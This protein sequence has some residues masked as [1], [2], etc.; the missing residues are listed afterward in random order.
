MGNYKISSV[1]KIIESILETNFNLYISIF[2]EFFNSFNLDDATGCQLDIIGSWFGYP[3]PYVIDVNTPVFTYDNNT[4][5]PVAL[6]GGWKE[7]PTPPPQNEGV[8][9]DGLRNKDKGLSGDED[10]R[11]LLKSF[12]IFQRDSSTSGYSQFLNSLFING[13]GNEIDV[14]IEE[15]TTIG[16]GLKFSEQLNFIQV[17]LAERLIPKFHPAGYPIRYLENADGYKFYV[18]IN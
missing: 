7:N 18:F 6:Q 8:W 1:R 14:E 12:I 10:Y 2:Y 11:R 9:I 17:D 4:S 3:R 13:L 5:L 15:L 16:I